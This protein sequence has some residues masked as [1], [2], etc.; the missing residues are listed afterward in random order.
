MVFYVE[1][2]NQLKVRITKPQ[3]RAN[4]KAFASKIREKLGIDSN[5]LFVDVLY[6]VEILIPK[7]DSTFQYEIFDAGQI[8]RPNEAF[9]S[10]EK[11]CIFIRSDVYNKARDE[12]G[13]ARFTIAHEIAHYFLFKL[14]GVPYFEAWEN[15]MYFSDAKLHSVDPE[16]QADVVGNYLLCEPESIKDFSEED[17]VFYC[18][19]TNSAAYT[20]LQNA[21]GHKYIDYSSMFFNNSFSEIVNEYSK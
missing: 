17:V 4:L 3:S 5:Q 9:Y 14:L 13:R 16:W 20:A 12:D 11:N 10:P 19:V 1:N 7:I 6:C 21:Q 2:E 18:G 15:I 8:N